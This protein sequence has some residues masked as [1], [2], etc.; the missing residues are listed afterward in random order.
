MRLT[1]YQILLIVHQETFNISYGVD[2]SATSY[3]VNYTEST[4]G[5]V[6]ASNAFLAMSCTNGICENEFKF[7]SSSCSPSSIITVTAAGTNPL[8]TGLLSD[9]VSMLGITI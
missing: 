8:G 1:F 4:S 7:T 3:T 2:G 5:I 6:C 9:P